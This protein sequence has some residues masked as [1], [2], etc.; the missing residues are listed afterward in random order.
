[1]SAATD[2]FLSVVVF[3]ISLYHLIFPPAHLCLDLDK[4]LCI[5]LHPHCAVGEMASD[6]S[7][8]DDLWC[9]TGMRNDSLEIHH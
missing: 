9:F 3:L 8:L 2:T 6:S 4:N 7:R 1:M 5:L